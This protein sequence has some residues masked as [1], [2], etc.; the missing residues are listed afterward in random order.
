LNRGIVYHI[1]HIERERS[2]EALAL[3]AIQEA[4]REIRCEFGVESELA[5]DSQQ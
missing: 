4:S 5:F 3:T 1:Y 2:E